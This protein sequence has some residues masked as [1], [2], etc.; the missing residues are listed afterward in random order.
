MPDFCDL[1]LQTERLR[2]RVDK[3][4]CKYDYLKSGYGDN[5]EDLD[6]CVAIINKHRERFNNDRRKFRV[7]AEELSS[8][9]RRVDAL[10]KVKLEILK[11]LHREKSDSL[12]G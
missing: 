11:Y 7:L 6:T 8:L 3:L 2:N 1:V 10:L 5:W 12:E 9:G 4:E